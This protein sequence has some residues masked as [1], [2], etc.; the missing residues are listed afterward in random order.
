[1]SVF[2][3]VILLFD[4]IIELIRSL[5]YFHYKAVNLDHILS[6]GEMVSKPESGVCDGS[7]RCW[8]AL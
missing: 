7:T 2:L 1:M 8:S 5:Q 4:D 6:F 3:S